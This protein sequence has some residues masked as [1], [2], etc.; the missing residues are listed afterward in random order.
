M[1]GPQLHL[2]HH[3]A[4]TATTT[5]VDNNRGPP[6]VNHEVMGWPAPWRY[7]SDEA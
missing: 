7:N 1:P 5:S 3:H 4:S 6:H 2:D